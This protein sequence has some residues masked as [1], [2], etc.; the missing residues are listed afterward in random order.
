MFDMFGA[1]S[2][3]SANLLVQLSNV[4]RAPRDTH[5]VP[6]LSIIVPHFGN[7]GPL[8]N[9]LASVLQNR[10]AD[11]EL[12]LV[13]PG[14]YEDPYDLA[15]E[16]RFVEVPAASSLVDGLNL[17]MHA[18][19]GEFIHVVRP[20]V[21]VDERWT[22]KA[23]DC[24]DDPRVAAVC[25]LILDRERSHLIAE[26]GVKLN[27]L[28]QRRR[29]GAKAKNRLS[30]IAKLAPVGPSLAAAFYRR[31]ALERV[32]WLAN[33][34]G[35]DLA[36]ID[37]ALSLV[38]AGYACCFEPEFVLWLV[39]KDAPLEEVSPF[40]SG[41]GSERM[42]CRH[43]PILG[44]RRAIACRPAFVAAQLVLGVAKPERFAQSLGRVLAWFEFPRHRRY[45]RELAALRDEEFEVEEHG[46]TTHTIPLDAQAQTATEDGDTSPS[47]PRLKRV[48]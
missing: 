5:A 12:L 34:I 27:W 23:I 39:E 40:A 48:S 47:G 29:V 24:F 1:K 18:A 9:T 26:A 44:G 31:S 35:A 10:P 32:G 20:G 4:G 22:E 21:E 2:R 8:E 28:G 25:P 46:R 36:D 15:G 7:T 33:D 6:C 19:A 17:G 30:K 41:R 43:A 45:W 38:Q 16:I 42:L 3:N 13:H 11:C 14:T 37:V